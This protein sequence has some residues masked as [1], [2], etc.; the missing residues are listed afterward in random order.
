MHIIM[1][2][3]STYYV[4]V[5][6]LRIQLLASVFFNVIMAVVVGTHESGA[7]I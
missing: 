2:I 6:S 4:D 5:A 7:V 1:H 3:T